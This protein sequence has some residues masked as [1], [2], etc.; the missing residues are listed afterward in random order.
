MAAAIGLWDLVPTF[1]VHRG[2]P[3][4]LLKA[5]ESR[6][7]LC[8]G[9]FNCLLRQR[10]VV[11]LLLEEDGQWLLDFITENCKTFDLKILKVSVIFDDMNI[12]IAF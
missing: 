9:A 5:M 1:S 10:S 6:S 12:D 7:K 8:R 3:S 2:N 4:V 11:P